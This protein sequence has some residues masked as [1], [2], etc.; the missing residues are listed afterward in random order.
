[1]EDWAWESHE[2]AEKNVYEPLNPKIAIE[3]QV[4][5]HSCTDDNNI[6]TRLLALHLAA[7]AAYQEQAAPVVEEQIAKAGVRL[8]MILNDTAKATL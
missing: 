8:A 6:G 3:P 5:V 2:R 1:V 4:T 7:G